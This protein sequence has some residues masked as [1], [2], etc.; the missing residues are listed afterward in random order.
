MS[1]QMSSYIPPVKPPEALSPSEERFWA[2]AS[3]A[4]GAV[5]NFLSVGIFGTI[6]III[7]Y[8]IFKNRSK[9]VAFQS[10][11]AFIFQLAW[12]A[13]MFCVLF[14]GMAPLLSSNDFGSFVL[15]EGLG[16][17]FAI[18]WFF[19]ATIYAII[20]AVQCYNGADFRYFIIGHLLPK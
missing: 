15:A 9:Y 2:A 16:I 14:C 19:G 12:F 3:H 4:A 17:G 11:Q 8:L 18:I 5:L 10:L 1:N 13:G 7:I 6:A 20:G